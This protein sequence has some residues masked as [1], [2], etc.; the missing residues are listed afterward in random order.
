MVTSLLKK[1]KFMSVAMTNCF[2]KNFS[3]FVLSRQV[4]ILQKLLYSHFPYVNGVS[5]FFMKV[6]NTDTRVVH[7]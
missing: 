5:E 1:K 4:Q 2:Y 3:F 7:I 6:C